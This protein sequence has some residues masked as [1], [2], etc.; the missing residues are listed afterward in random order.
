MTD[1]PRPNVTGADREGRMTEEQRRELGGL[2]RE[3]RAGLRPA[4]VGLPEG[5]RRRAPGLRRE[6][7][8]LLAGVSV[9]WYT[10]LEQGRAIR[11]SAGT[12]ERIL[13][14]LRCTQEERLY[15]QQLQRATPDPPEGPWNPLL[16]Q[17]LDAF[18]PAPALLLNQHWERTAQ[19]ATAEYLEFFPQLGDGACLLDLMFLGAEA[20]AIVRDWPDQARQLVA[21]FRLDSSRYTNDDWFPQKVRQLSA[22]SPDFATFWAE[23]QV[24]DHAAVHMHLQ[25]PEFGLLA[26]NATWLQVSG[27]PH[28][29]ILVC[30]ADPGSPTAAALARMAARTR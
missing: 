24:R 12:L 30:T 16:Q 25:H 18:L 8:A 20:R 9:A 14:A 28:F 6:E 17:V 29:K 13:D 19:N 22:A 2:L 26:L 21:A 5:I 11:P 23:R 3:K 7:V 1:T 4:D 10:W 27:T 15:I